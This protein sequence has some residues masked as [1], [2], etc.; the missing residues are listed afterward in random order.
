MRFVSSITWRLIC[1]L[2]LLAASG[3]EGA[4]PPHLQVG[5]ALFGNGVQSLQTR[6]RIAGSEIEARFDR[7]LAPSLRT[8]LAAGALLEV[9]ATDSRFQSDFLPR[10][11]L[12]LRQAELEW[13]PFEILSLTLGALDQQRLE[14]PLLIERQTFPG[15]RQ[16]LS[17]TV[18]RVEWSL[19]AQQSIAADTSSTALLHPWNTS[20]TSQLPTFYL[21]RAALGFSP[22]PH[23]GLK[24]HG[25]H[26]RFAD[27]STPSALQSAFMGN[28]IIGQVAANARYAYMFEG[29]EWG[30]G[31]WAQTGKLRPQLKFQAIANTG[32]PAE[33][34]SG[35]RATLELAWQATPQVV[36]TPSLNRFRMESD[37]A[38]AFYSDRT[39][40]HSN[41]NG[42][43]LGLNVALPKEKIAFE[44]SWVDARVLAPN[45]R[46]SDLQWLALQVSTNHD[47]L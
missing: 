1:A 39:F 6:S 34:S 27:L 26:F 3:V 19:S 30:L 32:A 12:R 24:A 14:S 18:A 10:R 16:E 25:S 2:P 35:W 20:G 43:G 7:V 33:Q 31:V 8:R 13:A 21:E 47:V 4:Q 5:I 29:W 22:N 9:G 40:G 42:F 36:I 11:V 41:R 17:G 38:P 23:F 15:F 37:A 28:T 44:G 45:G 46:Q